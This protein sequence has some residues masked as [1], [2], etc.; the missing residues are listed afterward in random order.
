M[1]TPRDDATSGS[2]SVTS[3]VSA[4]IEG[5]DAA[6]AAYDEMLWKIRGGYA[7]VL[8]GAFTLVVALSDK[9]K[10]G[11]SGN[12]AAAVALILI[13]GFTVCA[14]ALDFHFLRSKLRVVDTKEELVDLA[15]HLAA[16]AA[17]ED[18][19]GRP[20]RQ[21]LYNAG[22]HKLPLR[23]LDY[24]SPWPIWLLYIGTWAP[25][26]LATLLMVA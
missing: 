3:L 5:K 25:L 14:A 12:K 4:G 17:L 19:Q 18:W 20:L 13:T 7:A 22:E 23:P 1:P 26:S 21:L 2:I 15:L 24:P 6:L 10:V 8:Y 16:G 9:A 11:L